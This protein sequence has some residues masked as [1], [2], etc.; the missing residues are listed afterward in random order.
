MIITERDKLII[1]TIAKFRF[2]QSRHI[3]LL[4]GFGGQRA[5]DRRLKK[6]IENNFVDRKRILYGTAGIYTITK[7]A[8]K[9]FHIDLSNSK[10]RVEQIQHD[11]NVVDTA[12]YFMKKYSLTL[13]DIKTEKELQ[14]E[15]GFGT[16]VHQPD[17]VFLKDK[18]T[19]CVEI[20]MSLKAKKRL[21][22]IL[23]NNFL[24]YDV[25]FWIIP[26]EQQK[27][28]EFVANS[29]NQFPNIEIVLL[30]TIQEYISSL[31]L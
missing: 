28:I 31:K 10:I 14:H 22:Q 5:T 21:E 6:L 29:V 7:K 1:Y 9:Q 2:L 26:D 18:E 4:C 11:I 23:K 24:N 19:H 20:E 17:F 8:R 25:Q 27:I 30:S 16:R 3:K 13:D 12:I 15:R